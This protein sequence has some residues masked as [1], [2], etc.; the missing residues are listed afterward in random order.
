MKKEI[1]FVFVMIFLLHA[2]VGNAMEKAQEM[3]AFCMN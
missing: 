3:Y 1:V 2:S